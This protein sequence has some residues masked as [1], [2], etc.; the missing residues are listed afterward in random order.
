MPVS[1]DDCLTDID[2]DLVDNPSTVLPPLAA[3]LAALLSAAAL[4]ACGGGGSDSSPGTQ[5]TGSDPAT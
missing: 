2:A 5:P 1:H 4:S 3:P